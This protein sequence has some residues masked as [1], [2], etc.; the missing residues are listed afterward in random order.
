MAQEHQEYIQQKVNPILENLVTQLL[1]ERPEQLAPFMIKW[2]SQNSKTPAAAA[3]TEGVNVLSE[4]K[5]E[6]EKLQA[7]VQGLEQ[8]VACKE[9]KEETDDEEEE[10]APPASYFTTGPRASV[11]AEAYGQWNPERVFV[12]PVFAKTEEQKT[13]LANILKECFLFASIDSH[14][15]A[16]LI[17][18][19]QEKVVEQ[20]TRLIN[21]GDDGDCL[22][23]IEEGQM[24]CFIQS[25]EGE[26]KV[27]ECVAG[28]L[29]G[30]LALLYNCPRAASVE[31]AQRCVLWELDRESFNQIVK[32]AAISH[33]EQ[34]EE[35]LEK[36]PLL[37]SMETYER[38]SLCDALHAVSFNKGEVIVQQGEIG[39]TFYILEEGTA[40]VTK[41]YVAGTPAKEVLR[42]QHG[43]YFG[44]LALLNNEPRA[45]SVHA[46][47]DC[48][49]YTLSRRTF[50][51]LLG[52]LQEILQRNAR[53]YH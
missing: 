34:L 49:C 1:L 6:M 32:K 22:Y 13:R 52:P 24:N 12:P 35:F 41:V 15:M 8:Q 37:Q 31:A 30:E 43:A 5:V 20:G 25:S 27:K 47:T 23:V 45:A 38:S 18:A 51:R 26:R 46:A 10:I 21:Q 3:L 33:R 28:D 50:N 16:I 29:F 17:D 53:E 48:Q 39:D 7:E 2:L 19:M 9:E 4:L 44:E 14:D 42:L 36:V 40:V 11:S